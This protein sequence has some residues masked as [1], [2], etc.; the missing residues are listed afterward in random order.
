MKITMNCM[1]AF[2][3]VLGMQIEREGDEL[4]SEGAEL[5]ITDKAGAVEGPTVTVGGEMSS[6][7]LNM[8][9]IVSATP[10]ACVSKWYD[11]FAGWMDQLVVSIPVM[12]MMN[13]DLGADVLSGMALR[14]IDQSPLGELFDN[15][16]LEMTLK[17]SKHTGFVSIG[18]T[19][20]GLACSVCFGIPWG[21]NLVV[22]EGCGQRLAEFFSCPERLM[23]SWAVGL[24][25]TRHP[26]PFATVGE[27]AHVEGLG[28][29]TAKHIYTPHVTQYRNSFYTDNTMIALC[30]SWDKRL[31]DANKRVLSLCGKITV[32]GKQHRTDLNSAVQRTWAILSN[33][34]LINPVDSET[35]RPSRSLSAEPVS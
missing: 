19:P 9:D 26:Y 14:Y 7:M 8:L 17:Q 32:E 28:R 13:D 3:S 31:I 35:S 24:Y 10:V 5:T 15:E 27:R 25:V 30:T 6:S 2:N 1:D 22:L 4:V 11:P 21:G 34:G 18:I 12:G 23:E 16:L 29:S 20:E 33:N